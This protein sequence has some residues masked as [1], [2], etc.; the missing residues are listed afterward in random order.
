MPQVAIQP[1]RSFNKEKYVHE[2]CHEQETLQLWDL[3]RENYNNVAC[4]QFS[5]AK[6]TENI[7]MILKFWCLVL[8]SEMTM[9]RGNKETIVMTKTI[10]PHRMVAY[11]IKMKTVWVIFLKCFLHTLAKSSWKYDSAMFKIVFFYLHLEKDLLF[12]GKDSPWR[13]LYNFMKL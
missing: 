11:I 12:L 2:T 10:G 5:L 1:R 13:K 3:Q 4:W 9:T 7:Y 6:I 8:M